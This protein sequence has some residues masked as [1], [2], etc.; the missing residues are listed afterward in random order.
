MKP[1]VRFLQVVLCLMLP[2]STTAGLISVDVY[3]TDFVMGDHSQANS[4]WGLVNVFYD[5]NG[6]EQLQYFNLLVDGRWEVRNAPLFSSPLTSSRS[7]SVN[8][9][10]GNAVGSLV[11]T[12]QC[13]A[14]VGTD[15]LVEM[16][17]GTPTEVNV[18][19]IAVTVGGRGIPWGPISAAYSWSGG[20]V[21]AEA[22]NWGMGNQDCEVDECSPAAFSNSLQ[23][24]NLNH[25]SF[26]IPP[27]KMSIEG[28]KGPMKWKAPKTDSL[29][30][31]IPGTGG[32]PLDDWEGKR[33]A[34]KAYVTTRKFSASELSK[35][36]YEM[37]QGQDI[38]LLGWTHAAVVESIS[39]NADGTYTLG[40]NHD[41]QQGTPGGTS[42]QMLTIDP[43]TGKLLNSAYGFKAGDTIDGFVV[44]CPII[45]EPVFFQMGA[46]AGLGGIGMLRMLGR[47]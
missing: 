3:Q 43:A 41:M 40:I 13:L 16:P 22:H 36:L 33:D 17:S 4:D 45:P 34:L 14:T 20:Q 30:N 35:V 23:W 31:P 44:E 7:I 42:T 21:V 28:L 6:G 1:F 25:P 9:S 12:A 18:S 39:L 10:L 47:R 32:T 24:L 2:A 26:D 29:G 27:D 38:E 8:F 11:E 19:K 37:K 5:W 15:W 46:L